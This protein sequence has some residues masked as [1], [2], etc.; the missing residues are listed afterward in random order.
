M[1]AFE[2]F[3]FSSFFVVFRHFSNFAKV[4]TRGRILELMYLTKENELEGPTYGK[5]LPKSV[6]REKVLGKILAPG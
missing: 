1:E 4:G 2:N 3:E 5:I 6:P